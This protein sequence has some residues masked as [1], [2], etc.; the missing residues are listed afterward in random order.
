M[1]FDEFFENLDY[2]NSDH[3]Y[4]ETNEVNSYSSEINIPFFISSNQ[5]E[6]VSFQ[7]D[8]NNLSSNDKSI[9]ISFLKKKTYK[10]ISEPIVNK[11]ENNITDKNI[12]N[13]KDKF[14][15]QDFSNKKN[16]ERKYQI[17]NFSQKLFKAINDWY[18]SKINKIA[19]NLT[20]KEFSTPNYKL[21][22]HN[23][24]KK[25]IFIFLKF[26][27]K[28]ILTFTLNDKKILD[29]ILKVKGYKRR[30]KYPEIKFN[31]KEQKNLIELLLILKKK[32][33]SNKNK[34]T[35][36]DKNS[37]L[38]ILLDKGYKNKNEKYLNLISEDKNYLDKLLIENNIINE[39]KS[40]KIQ[41][42]NKD[43]IEIIKQ[44]IGNLPELE[45]EF[46]E[47]I[48][49]YM[50]DTDSIKFKNNKNIIKIN[51]NFQKL[52]NSSNYS[53]LEMYEGKCGFIKMIEKD[54]SISLKDKN[55]INDL[56]DFLNDKDINEKE[57]KKYLEKC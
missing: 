50:S 49:K 26:K 10:S 36:I 44:K 18:L 4:F 7:D 17:D 25:D 8:K 41:E 48:N 42:N 3:N 9:N 54:S 35:F 51:E 6:K 52:K 20:N 45:I 40:Y 46:G 23:T 24:N 29:E 55:I 22:T 37:L 1:Q 5:T 34:I 43:L 16:S 53:L 56:F 11:E 47:L 14:I 12:S 32:D 19:K 15:N 27:Y 57:L 13:K 2:N 21:I 31:E 30:R 28:D 39:K 38:N 33:M